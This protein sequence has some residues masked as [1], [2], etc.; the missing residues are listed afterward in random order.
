MRHEM[1]LDFI[2]Q[3]VKK[4][5]E[6]SAL[7]FKGKQIPDIKYNEITQS[8]SECQFYS[9]RVLRYKNNKQII[10]FSGTVIFI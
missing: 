10:H 7:K 1:T 4:R 9:D 8:H 6:V 3:M 2:E 5:G